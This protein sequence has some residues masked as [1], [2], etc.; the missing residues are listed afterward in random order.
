MPFR[1]FGL[2]A[3]VLALPAT[4]FAQGAG[5]LTA[6]VKI[7]LGAITG[8]VV[9]SAE[10]VPEDLYSFRAT[11]EVRSI[12]ELFGHVADALF[13]MC[14]TAGGS[15]PPRTGIEKAVTA[16]PAL[17]AALKESV[18]YCYTVIDGM[19]DQKGTETV[20]FY[21]GPTP[22]LSVLYFA[23]THTYEHYGNLVT[24]MRLKNIVPPSSEPP[25]PGQ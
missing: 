22:R 18:S 17:I 21:F 15:K 23:V 8:F 5:P 12:A 24:Y 4:S 19:T 13:S 20:P 10:K 7:Q 3:L 1:H 11:P 6:N 14:S 9:R 2:A 16:K 25:K